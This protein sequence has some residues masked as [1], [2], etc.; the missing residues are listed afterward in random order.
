MPG[1]EL[2]PEPY[3]K[4]NSIISMCDKYHVPVDRKVFTLLD[5]EQ[6]KSIDNR[7]L[8]MMCFHV[9]AALLYEDYF[10][11]DFRR[12]NVHD[13]VSRLVVEDSPEGLTRL[14]REITNKDGD[15]NLCLFFADSIEIIRAIEH[16]D[17]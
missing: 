13:M 4:L 12:G 6:G 17:R 16:Y 1:P 14:F 3:D 2:N 9:M 10:N 11:V 8:R 7:F 15:I 5:K